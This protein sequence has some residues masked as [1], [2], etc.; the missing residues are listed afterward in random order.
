MYYYIFFRLKTQG[1]NIKSKNKIDSKV[2]TLLF[3]SYK[4]LDYF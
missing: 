2:V 1:Q 3:C 4:I